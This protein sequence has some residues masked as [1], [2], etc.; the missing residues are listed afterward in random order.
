MIELGKVDVYKSSHGDQPL[1]SLKKGN[2][3]GEK[4]LF[5]ND[6]RTATCVAS[7]RVKCLVLAREDFVRLFGDLQDLLDK[8]Q[9]MIDEKFQVEKRNS[10]LTDGKLSPLHEDK[11]SK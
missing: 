5:S 2:F 6:T 7:D 10:L 4:A 8:S 1:V 11:M 9:K 3:F